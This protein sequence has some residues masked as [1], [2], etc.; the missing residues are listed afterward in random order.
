MGSEEELKK[1]L[2]AAQEEIKR[3]NSNVESATR[4]T[5]SSGAYEVNNTTLSSLNPLTMAG[6]LF[7]EIVNNIRGANL[8]TDVEKL[9][10]QSQSLANSMGI[11]AA[12]S[13]ELRAMIA[14]TVPEM[15]KLGYSEQ[16]ALSAF[17]KIPVALKTN[18]T[19]ATD[20]I[21]GLS[22]AAKIAGS[23]IGVLANSFK[24]VGFNL[25]AVSK[26]MADTANYAKGI[27]VNV[28]AVSK[29]VVDNIGK[30]NTMNFDGG[31]RGLSKMVAQS[32]M[33]GVNMERVL[34]KAND[35][36]N[37]EKAID[38][39]SAL[40]RLG[41]QSSS[42]LDPLSAMD[43]ALNDPAELQNQMVKISQQ[44]TRL[45]TDGTG[46]EI[47]PGAKLQLKEV[48]EAMGMSG[49]ELA[50][51]AIK[52][53]DLQMK[54]SKIRFP[55]LGV[56]EDDKTLIANMAQMKDGRAV[57]QIKND[58][59]GNVDEVDV[60]SLTA[61]QIDKLK[62]EQSNQNKSAIDIAKEQLTILEQ[63]NQN[64]AAAKGSMRMGV[65][66]A[67]AIQRATNVMAITQK[68]LKDSILNQVSTISTREK[69]TS[70][71]Q[72]IERGII[73]VTTGGIN[74]KAL[75]GLWSELSIIPSKMFDLIE[76]TGTLLQTAS[77]TFLTNSEFNIKKEYSPIT[78]NVPVKG[79]NTVTPVLVENID[80]FT[81]KLSDKFKE[82]RQTLGVSGTVDVRVSSDRNMTDQQ[83]NDALKEV[84]NKL[85]QDNLRNNPTTQST[86]STISQTNQM[87]MGSGMNR[88]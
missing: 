9:M 56:S 29:G 39:S 7:S 35:I 32:E 86:I 88:P 15:I 85:V 17:E 6:D 65:A 59:T 54:M 70:I 51:M 25:D 22:A 78:G 12:R 83:F 53:S 42:L 55:S 40:Q 84:V 57:V 11:G 52:S 43:M 68:E 33:L 44:F 30:L 63:I 72:P 4:A 16:E 38:F 47:L 48:A 2:A 80:N 81:N 76:G 8:L 28:T 18:T 45:R 64:T 19:L 50:K 34:S 27:G 3:L 1:K 20:T 66:S 67:P 46:F 21:I 26:I 62:E 60:E 79:E 77:K 75:E 13:G 36:M 73:D 5:V 23:D 31:V 49:E 24:E 14:N 74:T 71:A 10:K 61:N 87:A 69:V 41:V 82:I 58:E 37:P